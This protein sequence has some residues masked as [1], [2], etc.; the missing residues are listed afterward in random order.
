[1]PEALALLPLVGALIYGLLRGVTLL[2]A[3]RD[4]LADARSIYDAVS[5]GVLATIVLAEIFLV[6]LYL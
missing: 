2:P 6:I 4:G 1:M 3:V 5:V